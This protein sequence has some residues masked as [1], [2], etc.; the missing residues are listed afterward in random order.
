MILLKLNTYLI[1]LS[2]NQ[3]E[4]TQ[5]GW[6]I[7]VPKFA[8]FGIDFVSRKMLA[9]M[10]CCYDIPIPV[11]CKLQTFQLNEVWPCA[12]G[13]IPHPVLSPPP[14]YTKF[15]IVS[16]SFQSIVLSHTGIQLWLDTYLCK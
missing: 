3:A 16:E 11:T 12:A 2:A 13:W 9:A 4:G 14:Y 7:R 5:L 10:L 15:V 8:A 6:K 1:A